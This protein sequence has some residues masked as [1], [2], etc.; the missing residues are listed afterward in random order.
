MER[1][2]F[3]IIQF[4]RGSGRRGGQVR[5]ELIVTSPIRAGSGGPAARA[6][7]IN[8]YLPLNAKFNGSYDRYTCACTYTIGMPIIFIPVLNLSNI[9][10]QV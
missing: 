7:Q 5:G 3:V 9:P 8:Y 1:M 6:D 4:R 10:I 2:N